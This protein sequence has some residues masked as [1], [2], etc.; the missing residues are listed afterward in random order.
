MK[1]FEILSFNRELLY[2]LSKAGVKTDDYRYIDLFRDFTEMMDEGNKTTY[3]VA[4]LAEKY[5]ISVRKVY[6]VIRHLRSDCK[7]STV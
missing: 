7:E 5:A 3:I 4:V 6:S 2:R 1:I